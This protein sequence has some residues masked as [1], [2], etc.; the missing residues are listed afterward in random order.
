MEL[1][2]VA[3]WLNYPHSI[4]NQVNLVPELQP[5]ATLKLSNIISLTTFSAAQ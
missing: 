4:E 3:G 5:C 2:A 1:E